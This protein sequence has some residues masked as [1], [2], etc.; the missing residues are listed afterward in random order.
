[1]TIQTIKTATGETLVILPLEEYEALEDAADAT[2][3]AAAIAKLKRGESETLTSKEMKA[4]L[5]APKPLAFWRRKRGLTQ[6][7]LAKRGGISQS[8]LASLE[9]GRRQGDPAL[10]KRL[11]QALSLRMEDLVAD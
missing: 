11:A 2:R 3:H 5:A 10:I 8:Y 7:A 6:A 4:L 9:T 1:M